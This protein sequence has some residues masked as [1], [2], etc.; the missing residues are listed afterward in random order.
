M[1]TVQALQEFRNLT[2]HRKSR[3]N[4]RDALAKGGKKMI[5][6]FNNLKE[7]FSNSPKAKKILGISAGV[8]TCVIVLTMTVVTMRKTVV[9]SI[10]GNEETYVT[11]KGTVN[12]VL[13]DKGIEIDPKDK[14]Q[15]E[16]DTKLSEDATVMVKKAVDVKVVVAGQELELKTAEDTIGEML[17]AEDETLKEIG[18]E[19][20]AEFDEVT[21]AAD[22]QVAKDLQ[23]QLVQVEVYEEL[24]VEAI[25]Y[26]TEW[27]TDY[28]KDVSYSQVKTAGANGEKEVTYKYVKKDGEVVSKEI[29]SVKNTKAAQTQ[30]GVKGGSYLVANRGGETVKG[31]KQIICQSTAYSGGGKT[32]TGRPVSYNPGGLSTIAVDPRVIPLGSKVWVEGYGYAIAADTGGAIKGNI[33]DVYFDSSSQAKTWGRKHGVKVLIVA[34]PGEW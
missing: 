18:V 16:L 20:N 23:V 15:P 7:I 25:P 5:E 29:A 3:Y 26:S 28:D 17:V 9:I 24:A 4:S 2:K 11:Y 10:D 27:E 19:Y 14:V 1:S 22:T 21:P 12:D 33:V 8:A 6:K 30:I 34:Y 13:Q 32:A 31:K